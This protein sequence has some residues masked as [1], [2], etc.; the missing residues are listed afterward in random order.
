MSDDW[1]ECFEDDY[2][3]RLWL[4]GPDEVRKLHQQEWPL[5]EQEETDAVAK[6][7]HT[8]AKA[9][10]IVFGGSQRGGKSESARAKL[11]ELNR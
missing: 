5:P 2:I 7:R 3:K 11:K 1:P 8:P 10:A 6:D 4:M 9:R